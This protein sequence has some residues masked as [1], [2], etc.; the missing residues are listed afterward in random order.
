MNS[1]VLHTCTLLTSVIPES[2]LYK[3]DVFRLC[4]G[5]NRWAAGAQE[6]NLAE[7]RR[8]VGMIGMMLP[9]S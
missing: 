9:T 6:L 3:L 5:G 4:S 2:P 7:H 8:L 1:I